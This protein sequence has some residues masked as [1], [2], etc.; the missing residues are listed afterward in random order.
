M[1][2]AAPSGHSGVLAPGTALQGDC[3]FRTV[4]T[5]P[6]GNGFTPRSG[7]T[8][9]DVPEPGPQCPWRARSAASTSTHCQAWLRNSG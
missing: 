8:V 4:L 9:M 3:A 6:Q 1:F 5:E 2:E 7:G